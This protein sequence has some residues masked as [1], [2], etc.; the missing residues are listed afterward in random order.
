MEIVVTL[1][2]M[3]KPSKPEHDGV[4]STVRPPTDLPSPTSPKVA[5][6]R[7]SG[8][9]D[10]H[11]GPDLRAALQRIADDGHCYIVVDMTRVPYVDSFALGVMVD[12]QRR[13]KE[14]GGDLYLTHI[15]PFVRRA[16]E[17][18][19]LVRIFN[20]VATV[21]EAMQ[22]ASEATQDKSQG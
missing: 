9:I 18:T 12:T 8:E 19:R 1:L 4:N 20:V 2:E 5:L 7:V 14:R 6:V 21:E 16:F 13:L 10:L 15:T 3:L 11:S 17:I 22:L